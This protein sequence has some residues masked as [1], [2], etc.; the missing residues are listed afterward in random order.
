MITLAPYSFVE[1]QEFLNNNFIWW[2]I[3][4]FPWRE[5]SVSKLW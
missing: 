3:S 4:H 1:A 5:Q 2:A